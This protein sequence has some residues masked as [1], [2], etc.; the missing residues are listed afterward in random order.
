MKFT[1]LDLLNPENQP[2]TAVV[3]IWDE[4]LDSVAVGGVA[5]SAVTCTIAL[6]G[7]SGVELEGTTEV[8]VSS[9]YEVFFW[10][11]CSRIVHRKCYMTDS[12]QHRSVIC[13]PLSHLSVFKWLSFAHFP[14]TAP[15]VTDCV[16]H[17]FAK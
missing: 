11:I 5:P 6:T 16:T 8:T 17:N 10:G 9:K 13:R 2:F 7:V 3:S 14:S 1:G 12:P 4:A 15:Y